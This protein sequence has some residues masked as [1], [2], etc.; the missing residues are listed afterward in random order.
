MSKTG[1]FHVISGPYR[2]FP[3]IVFLNDFD[4]SKSVLGSFFRVL[5]EK[6]T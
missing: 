4:A 6:L 5:C 3:N 2:D 1:T